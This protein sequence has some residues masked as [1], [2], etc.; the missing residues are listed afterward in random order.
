MLAQRA[1]VDVVLAADGTRMIGSPTLAKVALVQTG[2]T[3]GCGW[4]VGAVQL[5]AA[6]RTAAAAVDGVAKC[7]GNCKKGKV[8]KQWQLGLYAK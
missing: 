1:L 2:T 3:R 6:R 8:I 5:G 4:L 7:R